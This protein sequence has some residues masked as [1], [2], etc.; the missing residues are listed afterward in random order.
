MLIDFCYSGLMRNVTSDVVS[1]EGYESTNLISPNVNVR[2]KG[3][4][5]ECF[6]KPPVILTFVFECEVNINHI[7]LLTS[8][9]SQKSS[10]V[11]ISAR[12]L[13][14]FDF[15]S[16]SSGVIKQSENGFVFY[17]HGEHIMQM[18]P[19]QYKPLSFH[20][21][22][23]FRYLKTNAIKVKIFR[24]INS[25]I[26][27]L[28]KIEIWG[29]PSQNCPKNI[30]D[31]VYKT[32][33]KIQYEQDYN[34]K[35]YR[36]FKN[37]CLETNSI[38]YTAST[39]EIILKSE[40]CF[41]SSSK[42][43]IDSSTHLNHIVVPEEFVDPITCE[44]MV[45]PIILPSG[46]IIDSLT[47]E[48][49]TL[50]ESKWGRAASDPFTGKLITERHKT[51]FASDL[52]LR[53]DKFL[54]DHSNEASF[55]SLP[56]TVGRKFFNNMPT[57]VIRKR[58]LDLQKPIIKPSEDALIS[59]TTLESQNSKSNVYQNKRARKS[60]SIVMVQEEPDI[61]LIGL[62]QIKPTAKSV[63]R[64][65]NTVNNTSLNTAGNQV[66]I[67]TR[68]SD[69]KK[70]SYFK[71]LS[72]E[73][74]SEFALENALKLTLSTLPSYSNLKK[75]ATNNIECE[76]CCS[77]DSLFKLP[78]SHFLCRTCLVVITESKYLICVSCHTEFKTSDP[79]RFHL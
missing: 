27:T 77:N 36:S 51:V 72:H 65:V 41:N 18:L 14:S 1:S 62:N 64:A 7:V 30:V 10:G 35:S 79:E 73:E 75:F 63:S 8:V 17:K 9:G 19:E 68:F 12:S 76:K 60:K 59:Q 54:C 29:H 33:S 25:T 61:T 58:Y 44:I 50:A 6:V 43:D 42:N 28:G 21:F 78:C 48:K 5:A 34:R 13:E 24:T 71:K 66:I 38:P 22:K 11:E 56:R 70:T 67:E 49:H 69:N 32:W 52:K 55:K 4:L 3:F 39:S 20:T 23:S 46:K 45:L 26:P 2:K 57:N 40:L 16:L 15:Q 47:L 31:T 37:Q 74:E 53:I